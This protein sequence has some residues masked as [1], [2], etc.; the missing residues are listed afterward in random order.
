[1]S[2]RVTA[3]TRAPEGAALCAPGLPLCWADD[4]QMLGLGHD[5]G[6]LLVG[7]DAARWFD[8]PDLVALD[9]TGGGWLALTEDLEDGAASVWELTRSGAEL[10]ATVPDGAAGLRLEGGALV[11]TRGART[12]A[13]RLIGQARAIPLALGAERGRVA[14]GA[15]EIAWADGP[16]LY[17]RGTDGRTR[18]AGLAP[19][20]VTRLQIGPAGGLLA[21]ISGQS[22]LLR[23]P[24][25][26]ARTLT[27]VSDG[28]ALLGDAHVLLQVG[29]DVLCVPWGPGPERW[30]R[31]RELCG[32]TRAVFDPDEGRVVDLAGGPLLEELLPCA[33][34]ATEQAI[35]GPAGRRWPIMGGAP[36]AFDPDLLA[37]HLL[38]HEGYVLSVLDGAARVR[39]PGGVPSEARPLPSPFDDPDALLA[40]RPAR[41]GVVLVGDDE[42][43]FLSWSGRVR[44][45]LLPKS[46]RAPRS[47]AGWHWN[48]AGLLLRL[49]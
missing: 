39:P 29:D 26:H 9:A 15:A 16:D 28:P 21:T 2:G 38:A 45:G 49:R 14:V 17:R 37:E 46:R 23:S 47:P 41:G 40:L 10:R 22:T 25:G 7:A 3:L 43:V 42:R 32:S 12:R 27:L 33:A 48:D 31:E 18:T 4:G 13:A 8:L 30:L 5:D 20:P 35:L 34:T 36:G 44:R 6:V 19:G 24:E 11:E 1:V